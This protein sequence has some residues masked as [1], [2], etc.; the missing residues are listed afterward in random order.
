MPS[1]NQP[2]H[3][4]NRHQ[5]NYDFAH[6][7]EVSADLL[8][9]ISLNDHGNTSID[10]TDPTAVKALNAAIL[11]AYYKI[12]DW[13]IPQGQLCPA[14]PGRA[15]YVHYLAD[16]LRVSN[17]GKLP[18]KHRLTVLDIGTGAS[19]IYPLL[20]V[21]DYGWTFVATDI[22]PASLANIQNILAANPTFAAQITLRL[23]PDE[24][25]IFRHIVTDDDWFDISMCNPPFHASLAEAQSGTQ[26]KWNNLGKA[27][28]TKNQAPLLNFGGQGAELW[29]PGGELAF[30]ERMILESVA[31]S[32][33]CFW[34]SCL[35][36]KSANLV[37]LKA[38]L[39]RVH[40]QDL[41]EIDMAQ[42]NKQSRFL[43]WTF[44]T[45]T[46]QTAWKKLR[47]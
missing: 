25:A 28:S 41:R 12:V 32:G 35:V 21:A 37:P 11:K 20:G 40:V 44:L 47:W 22:N 6:L 5:G 24:K 31:I 17:Q 46:Q 34:F 15:D 7:T 26:R 33:R 23:Q 36:S 9:Y 39:K 43:A 45:P 38:L 14:I 19:G 3:P 29:C 42:G 16:L 8:D 4:A 30:I 18:K 13:N 2:F 1:K 10:F 27:Q